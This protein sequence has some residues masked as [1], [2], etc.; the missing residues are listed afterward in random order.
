MDYNRFHFTLWVARIAAAGLMAA[1]LSAWTPSSLLAQSPALDDAE[2]CVSCHQEESEAWEISPHGTVAP[3]S[4]G[5]TGGASCVDCHGEYVKGH[6]AE[7]PM[8]LSVDSSSC[9]DCHADTFAQWDDSHHASE[10]VQCISCHKPHSQQLRLTD[11]TLC[12]SCHRESLDDPFHTA[13]WQGDVTC[14]S[15][16]LADTPHMQMVAGQDPAMG[17]TAAPSHDFV[18]VSGQNCLDCHR[19]TVAITET[20][21][22]KPIA[23]QTMASENVNTRRDARNFAT[24]SAANLGFGLGIGGIL[25]IVFMLV[26]GSYH[27]GRK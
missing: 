8:S 3:E 11:E 13:H 21:S 24:L 14:T 23:E 20:A 25:G 7:G 22:T 12:Q 18:T 15:C 17:V 19:E 26:A 27:W 2:T 1:C 10:G 6:P 9:Q 4:A 16:H 5:E